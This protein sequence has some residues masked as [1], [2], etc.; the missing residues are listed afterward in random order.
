MGLIGYGLKIVT[1][2]LAPLVALI[3]LIGAILSRR[4]RRPFAG[5][6]GAVGA[7]LAG[8]FV[9]RV[10]APHDGFEE[11]F[12]P[13]WRARLPALALSK[14]GGSSRWLTKRWKLGQV[15]AHPRPQRIGNLTFATVPGGDQ[16]LLCDLWLPATGT[17]RSG[18]GLIYLHGGAWQ[19]F[20]KDVLTRPFFRHLTTQG[21]VV[22]DVAYR[23][24]RETDMRGMLGDVKRAVAWLKQKGPGIGVDP[25]KVVLAGGSAGGHLALLAAY[26]PNDPDLDP[27]DVRNTDTAVRGAVAYYPV[28]DLRTLSD[29]WSQQ[30]MHPL[31]T[32]LGKA[33][34]YFPREGYQTWSKL[35]QKLFG[36]PL[37]A[38]SGELL[39]FSP[40][41]HV[42]AHCP[43]TLILQG[44]H[45]HV[46]PI[47]D[48]RALTQALHDAGR[49]VVLVELPQVEHAFD[50]VAPQISPPA[51]AALY[52]V[53]RFLALMAQK[54]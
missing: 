43:P 36:A 37:D 14:S 45:D 52:D 38:I 11:A 50:L 5:Y 28:V 40:I 17:S 4:R 22:M 34:G 23:L 15:G 9:R 7:I 46:I 6:L 20:D 8:R 2:A 29:H 48:V 51:Q 24:V 3:A 1:G 12:G 33:L 21:H 35:A 26:T 53:E 18:L 32:A 13:D 31:A 39:R 10:S 44:L 54:D 27:P 47:E 41:S 16:P 42:G 19:A 30:S 49:P 25:S